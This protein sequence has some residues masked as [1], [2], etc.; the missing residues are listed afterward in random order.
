[1]DTAAAQNHRSFVVLVGDN[2]RNQ[3]V[4][5]HYLLTKSI[6]AAAAAAAAA[7]KTTVN[8]GAEKIKR[9]ARP[10]VLWCYKTQLHLSS[11]RRKRM[12]QN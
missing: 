3:V 4:T 9:Q 8:D 11:H 2:A 12:K 10:N 5:L 7:A 6:S 1:M